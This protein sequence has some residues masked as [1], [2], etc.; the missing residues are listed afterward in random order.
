M[1][2]G[3]WPNSLITKRYPEKDTMDYTIRRTT[4]E[5]L[6]RILELVHEFHAEGL[7]KYGLFCDD[8]IANKIMPKMVE[9][10]LVM[11]AEDKV[12]GVIA[13]FVTNHIVSNKRLFQEVVWFIS[14]KY[15]KYG[16]RLLKRMETFCKELECE[17]MVMV[18][19]GGRSEAFERFYTKN[20]YKLLEVQFIKQL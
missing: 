19:M 11:M 14:K 5:D 3:E 16:A 10:S 7:D 9:T 18:N 13:G 1:K 8:D 6:P 12:V 2:F 20:G 17:H 15:R 4:D